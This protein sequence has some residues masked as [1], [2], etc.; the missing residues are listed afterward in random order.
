MTPGYFAFDLQTVMPEAYTTGLF[1]N[2]LITIQAPDGTL[3]ATG[4]PSGTPLGASSAG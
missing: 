1:N 2:A 4:A 3:G